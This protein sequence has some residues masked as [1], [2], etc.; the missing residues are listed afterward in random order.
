MFKARV[1]FA[2]FRFVMC[3]VCSPPPVVCV[4]MSVCQERLYE[5]LLSFAL[6]ALPKTIL[7]LTVNSIYQKRSDSSCLKTRTRWNALHPHW[8]TIIGWLEC[9]FFFFLIHSWWWLFY[10]AAAAVAIRDINSRRALYHHLH[11]SSLSFPIHTLDHILHIF[12]VSHL[13]YFTRF[14]SQRMQRLDVLL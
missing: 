10:N 1:S 5:L 12:S 13:I 2:H 6:F 4:C 14:E 7:L 9:V 8:C 3:F 11:F